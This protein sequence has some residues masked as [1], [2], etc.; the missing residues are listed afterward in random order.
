MLMILTSQDREV[1]RSVRRE[2]QSSALELLVISPFQE[3]TSETSLSTA[4]SPACKA[5]RVPP[6][7]GH[8][9][10]KS[11]H[12]SAPPEGPAPPGSLTW[13][14]LGHAKLQELR[15][16]RAARS[17]PITVSWLPAPTCQRAVLVFAITKSVGNAVTRNRLRRRLREL[18]R[19]HLDLPDGMYLVRAQPS[20]TALSFTKLAEHLAR[21]MRSVTRPAMTT[22]PR[23]GTPLTIRRAVTDEK[24][25]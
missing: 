4:Q 1:R 2:L 3:A 25:R 19:Q 12:Q 10:R 21:A 17:G 14:N 22:P 13:N 8:T 24:T 18:A 6:P 15:S 23:S 9:C 7:Y 16:A 20:A 5:A 11:R